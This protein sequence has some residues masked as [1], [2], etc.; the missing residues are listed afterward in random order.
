MEN[1]EKISPGQEMEEK[2]RAFNAGVEHIE[3]KYQEFF[4]GRTSKTFPLTQ[5]RLKNYF[6]LDYNSTRG[7]ITFH[8]AQLPIS[9]RVEVEELFVKIW[10]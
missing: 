6:N 10:P 7:R 9:I 4:S 3:N 1:M 8:D 5:D 2:V